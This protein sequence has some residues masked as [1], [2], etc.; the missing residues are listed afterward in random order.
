MERKLATGGHDGHVSHRHC[1]RPVIFNLA[2]TM[3]NLDSY[4]LGRAITVYPFSFFP[5][6]PGYPTP[7][8]RRLSLVIQ[9]RLWDPKTGK[10]IGEPLK[11][12]S[13]WI[14]SLAWEPIHLC[15]PISFLD[16][17]RFRSSWFRCA[18]EF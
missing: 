1:S 2:D 14:T 17:S 6:S 8:A 15:V 4:S 7:S 18:L 13:K 10:P 9:V 16:S 5:G 12:H 3:S 11:G